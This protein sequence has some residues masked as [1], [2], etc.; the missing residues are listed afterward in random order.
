MKT[1]LYIFISILFIIPFAGCKKKSF[2]PTTKSQQ[3]FVGTWK[4]GISTFKNN[5]LLKRY[6][7]VVI[8]PDATGGMLSGILFMN[9]TTVFH[10]FQFVDGTLY[11][12]VENNDPDNP[13]CQNWNLQGYCVFTAD[14]EININ[15]TGNECGEVGNEFVNWAGTVQ[16]ATVP[17][18][19]VQYYNFAKTGN[20]WN[21]KVT[22]KNG[23]TCQFSKNVVL[24]SP[25]Y[26]STGTT[27]QTCG[28]P[29]P[30]LSFKWNVT[31]AVFSTQ[32]DS[33]ISN[34]PLTF[35]INAKQGVIYS[36]YINNDTVT[37]TLLDTNLTMV[38]PAGT[39]NC[40]RYR[41]TEPVYSGALR[42]KRTAYVWL[43]NR[44]G[45]IRQEVANPVDST[46][47]QTQVL[48]TKGF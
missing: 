2:D 15:I 48:T 24:A 18:D 29:S 41:Y 21:Y 13:F 23:D 3:D 7:T 9:G 35:K 22:L 6:G 10:E 5:K 14:G 38:T 43:N 26:L 12:N 25:N 1:Y 33:T 20:S 42:I 28:W 44:Y 19:S 37:M 47:V 46:N 30:N 34:K 11:F 40:M 16:A 36:S 39:F 32:V 45:I 31:P 8:Y 17:A 4:G 27:S